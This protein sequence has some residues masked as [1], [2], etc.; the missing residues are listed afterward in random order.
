MQKKSKLLLY[1]SIIISIVFMY[2]CFRKIDYVVFVRSLS[3]IAIKPVLLSI[4]CLIFGY[5]IR[6]I[7]WKYILVDKNLKFSNLFSASM[8]GNMGNN[9]FPLRVGEIIRC[10]VLGYQ[11]RISKSRILASVMFERILDGITVL[12]FFIVSMIVTNMGKIF[13]RGSIVATLIFGSILLIMIYSK[14][15]QDSFLKIISYLFLFFPDGIKIK[16]RQKSNSFLT[17]LDILHNKKYLMLS[18]IYSVLFWGSGITGAYF[19]LIATGKEISLDL[20]IIL[21]F[22]LVIGVMIPSAPGFIGTYH[23]VVIAILG[24]YGWDRSLSAGMS[25]LFHGIQ[26]MVPIIIGLFLTMRMGLNFKIM[27][28]SDVKAEIS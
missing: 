19:L 20:P 11:E 28:S 13:I 10:Y 1:T 15:Y 2:F 3:E 27:M 8:I 12:M 16:I 22:A 4:A 17:G 18:G 5:Y 9:I 25:V 24:M 7:R 21:N 14:K 6:A 23:F 26:F